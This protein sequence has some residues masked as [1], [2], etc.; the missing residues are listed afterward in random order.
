MG[1]LHVL[2]LA[3]NVCEREGRGSPHPAFSNAGWSASWRN[4]DAVSTYR[5]VLSRKMTVGQND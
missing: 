3:T 1:A 4:E 2:M 5:F